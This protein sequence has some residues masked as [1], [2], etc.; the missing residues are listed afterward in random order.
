MRRG[1]D[2][3]SDLFYPYLAG[4][5]DGDG[6]FQLTK[7][8]NPKVKRGFSWE[9]LLSIGQCSKPFLELLKEQI[10]FGIIVDQHPK[11]QLQFTSGHLRKLIPKIIPYLRRKC[12]QAEVLSQAWFCKLIGWCLFPLKRFSQNI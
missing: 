7:H 10:G 12:D 5:I 9:P 11:Y 1:I 4:F 6:C 8:K 2:M 3:N